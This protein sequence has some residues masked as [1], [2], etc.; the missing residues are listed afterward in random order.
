TRSDRHRP[1]AAY[2]VAYHLL[3]FSGPRGTSILAKKCPTRW[4]HY[5]G[6]PKT[7][8]VARADQCPPLTVS[9]RARSRRDPVPRRMA[10][11]SARAAESARCLVGAGPPRTH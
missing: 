11:G 4:P 6:F 1:A 7:S 10:A 8:L 5:Y 9:A 2:P 3:L